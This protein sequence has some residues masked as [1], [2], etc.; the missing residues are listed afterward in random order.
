[1][2]AD[3]ER[4]VDVDVVVIG[5]GPIGQNAAERARATGL[6]AAMV[7]RELVGG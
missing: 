6:S 4:D 3:S 1:M 7:E 5:A 2:A